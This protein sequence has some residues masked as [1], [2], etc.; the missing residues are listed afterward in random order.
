MADRNPANVN[1]QGEDAR[2]GSSVEAVKRDILDNLFYVVGRPV[3]HARPVDF[4]TAVAYTVR[5][6]ILDRYLHSL[7]TYMEDHVRVVGYLS[8][9]FL[10]GPQLAKNLLNLGLDAPF[11]QATRELGLDMDLLI[12]QEPEPGLG[13]GGLGTPRCL[14]PG[15]HGHDGNSFDWLRH[16]L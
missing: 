16:P 10:T 3:E 8:A 2:T 9:E 15:I 6:R 12:E 13:N 7:H 14:L 5:D 1:A 4:Y 11:R